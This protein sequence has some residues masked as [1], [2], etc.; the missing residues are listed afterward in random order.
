VLR[1]IP[2]VAQASWV[3]WVKNEWSSLF[4]MLIESI[5]MEALGAI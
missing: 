4:F 3:V 1:E 2:S 5:K